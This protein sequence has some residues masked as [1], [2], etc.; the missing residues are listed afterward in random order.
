MQRRRYE[1][2]GLR[3]QSRGMTLVELMIV[4][5][6][7]A[8]LTMIAVPGYRQYSERAHRTEAK[9]ALLLLANNQER[10]YLQNNT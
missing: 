7:I 4:V 6:I 3:G 10:F 1:K 5:V 8:I 9:N 2:L